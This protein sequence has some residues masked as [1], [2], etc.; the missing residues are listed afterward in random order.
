MRIRAC[1]TWFRWS[2]PVEEDGNIFCVQMVERFDPDRNIDFAYGC[3]CGGSQPCVHVMMVKGQ[4]CGWRPGVDPE[5]ERTP[6]VCPRCGGPV[7]E[8]D[9]IGT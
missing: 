1:S 6:G 2:T 3:D 8:I 7:V 5:V 4:H 9:V